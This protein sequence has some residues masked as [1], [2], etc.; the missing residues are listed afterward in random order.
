MKDYES[1]NWSSPTDTVAVERTDVDV[2]MGVMFTRYFG[3]F[4]GYKN[5]DAPLTY[6]DP[7]LGIS[8]VVL[9][10][11]T[12]KG[13]GIG[14]LAS[15]PL[16]SSAAIY[17]NLAVMKIQDQF[18]NAAGVASTANDKA[19]GSLELGLA[20]ALGNHFSSTLGYKVQVF[21]GELTNSTDV[22]TNTF[23]GATLGLNLI[24]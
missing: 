13:P 9:G 20:V 2:T 1:H 14:L 7:A 8:N 22:E 24:F 10:K 3:M 18:T 5:I 11:I 4:V 16:G 17:G 12:M 15:V 21:S 6:T 23:K 19:G